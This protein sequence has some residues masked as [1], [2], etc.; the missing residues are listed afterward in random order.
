MHTTL[1]LTTHNRPEYLAKTIQ[2]LESLQPQPDTVI[3]IDD[4][5]TDRDTRVL[6]SWYEQNLQTLSVNVGYYHTPTPKG[7]KHSLLL[8]CDMAF[9]ASTDLVINLDP[10]TLV[11]PNL[12][13]ELVRLHSSDYIVSGFNSLNTTP[14]GDLRNPIISEHEDHYIKQHAN[15]INMCFNREQYI[16]RIRPSLTNT[17]GNWD[18][19]TTQANPQGFK[20]AKPSLVQHIGFNSAM[21]HNIDPDVA[22][23]YVQLELP[24]VALFGIDAHDPTGLKR[25]ASICTSSV[26]FA[27]QLI[28]TEHDMFRGREGYS[29]YCISR[30]WG[31]VK[32][33]KGSHILLI[34]PDGY[35]VNPRAWEDDWLQYDF[36][37]ASWWYK[38]GM[39]VGN[40]GFSL[41]SKR[42]IETLS[43][44]EISPA[45]CHPEDEVICRRM[46]KWLEKQYDI[47]FAP[48]DVADRFAIEAYNTPANQYTGQFGFHGYT[49][50]GIPNPPKP[51]HQDNRAKY[52]EAA[53][54][55]LYRK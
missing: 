24:S 47:K 19:D 12:I 14:R 44:L 36:I 10:D 23:D 6:L 48:T 20:I 2:C 32:N 7:I 46:R 34:H 18:Y 37:G 22:A 38:D 11:K 50:T 55:S 21:G 54:R 39:N 30:M 53:K 43:N 28:I 33:L 49:V 5:S 29:H 45:E 4:G 16:N 13:S 1:I 17:S 15:G 42:L 41:R 26:A 27:D 25:A 3:I 31:D 35:I 52:Q 8:G 40:G 9:A 51:R